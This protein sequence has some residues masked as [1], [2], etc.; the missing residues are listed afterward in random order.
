V[1]PETS[2]DKFFMPLFPKTK[3]DILYTAEEYMK[4]QKIEEDELA[5][6]ANQ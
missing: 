4:R 2:N 3:D 1:F 5:K 6:K